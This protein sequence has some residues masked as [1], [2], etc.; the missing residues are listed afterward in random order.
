MM[1]TTA[2]RIPDNSRVKL[3][4]Y[5]D[6]TFYQ[7]LAKSGNEGWIRKHKLHSSGIHEVFIEWDRDHWA[8]NM[9]PNQWTFEEHFEILEKGE[10]DRM[11]EGISSDEW[12]QFQRFRAMQ[13]VESEPNANEDPSASK[14]ADNADFVQRRHFEAQAAKIPE[15]LESADSFFFISVQYSDPERGED[16]KLI[17]VSTAG[18]S[19][20]PETDLVLGMQLSTFAS[21]FHTE[22]ALMLLQDL[23]QEDG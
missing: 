7:G 14:P 4:D 21:K 19:M 18:S 5:I 9:Q 15:M 20:S 10:G 8:D 6:P 13:R 2:P 12:E 23:T 1:E 11:P 16:K 17:S 22:A 3:R